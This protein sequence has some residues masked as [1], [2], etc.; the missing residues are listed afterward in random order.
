MCWL[1]S[2]SIGDSVS[3]DSVNTVEYA[4]SNVSVLTVLSIPKDLVSLEIS[5]PKS[6][7]S[8]ATPTV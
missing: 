7:D 3:H 2:Y 1:L 4:S 8:D 6:L 5:S